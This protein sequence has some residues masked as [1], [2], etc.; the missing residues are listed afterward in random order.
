MSRAWGGSSPGRCAAS[1]SVI[2][3]AEA[4]T[5]QVRT[6]AAAANVGARL[7]PRMIVFTPA[8]FEILSKRRPSG[9]PK[10]RRRTVEPG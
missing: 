8:E 9:W 1:D 7:N 4:A 10:G 2:T 5:R 3:V 6:R